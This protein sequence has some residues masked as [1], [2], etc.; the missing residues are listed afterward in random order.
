MLPASLAVAGSNNDAFIRQ[1]SPSGSALGN[2]LS[3]DQS[4]ATDSTVRGIGTELTGKLPFYLLGALTANDPLVA[5]QRGESNSAELTLAGSGGELQLYQSVGAGASW[6]PYG[7]I[8]DNKAVLA[9]ASGALG[10]VL[11]IGSGNLATLKLGDNATGLVSQFGSK[12]TSDLDVG[13]GG[14]GTVV[15][16]GSNSTTGTVTVAPGTTL[17]YTQ[18]GSNRA[19]P[20]GAAASVFS[21]SLGTVTIQQTAW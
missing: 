10:G 7:A 8:A 13:A 9:A 6:M 11:Q 5:Q 2:T 21:T 18:I 19:P 17:I 1:V 3:I 20:P 12:L 15:Q 16:V 4:A 14:H